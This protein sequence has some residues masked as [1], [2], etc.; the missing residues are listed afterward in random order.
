MCYCVHL[1]VNIF[2]LFLFPSVLF[3]SFHSAEKFISKTFVGSNQL[4]KFFFTTRKWIH[5]IKWSLLSCFVF[6]RSLITS[7]TF[8][9]LI[10]KSD[11]TVVDFPFKYS[12]IFNVFGVLR[13]IICEKQTK[14]WK[15]MECSM[16][17]SLQIKF[18][19][20]RT[21]K[22]IKRHEALYILRTYEHLLT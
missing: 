1:F 22:K 21:Q 15:A 13:T 20:W 19:R 11:E 12:N 16:N 2:F 6:G 5:Q 18:T 3:V 14:N 7:R 8:F 10:Y 9:Y 4:F 17:F